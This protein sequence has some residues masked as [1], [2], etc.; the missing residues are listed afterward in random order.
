MV[1]YLKLTFKSE[2]ASENAFSEKR[3]T[4]IARQ[5]SEI[6][7]AAS[8]ASE[9]RLFAMLLASQK[10]SFAFVMHTRVSS[11][12]RSLHAAAAFHTKSDDV[13]KSFWGLQRSISSD[14]LWRDSI[15]SANDCSALLELPDSS[16]EW[17]AFEK[18]RPRHK[19][20][21]GMGIL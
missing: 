5:A 3:S 19:E 13:T 16:H 7:S 9:P 17:P 11:R 8:S 14:L 10:R 6:E 12:L 4:D 18:I 21:S 15:A 20:T 1:L 2:D